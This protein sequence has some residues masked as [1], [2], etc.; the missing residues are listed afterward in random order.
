MRALSITHLTSGDGFPRALFQ[1]NGIKAARPDFV[2]FNHTGSFINNM[3]LVDTEIVA[4]L[5]R[6]SGETDPW[7]AVVV[8]CS[9]VVRSTVVLTDGEKTCGCNGDESEEQEV[10]EHLEM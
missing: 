5:V 10:T 9:S 7:R 8:R 6:L 1:V 2:D 3:A 4:G